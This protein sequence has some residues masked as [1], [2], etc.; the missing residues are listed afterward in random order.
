MFT[1]VNN[2]ALQQLAMVTSSDDL[3]RAVYSAGRG[4]NIYYV[5]IC[6]GQASGRLL[7]AWTWAYASIAKPFL[8]DGSSA[9]CSLTRAWSVRKTW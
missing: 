8:I 1:M 6:A 3:E 2:Q 4:G 9:A 5:I 7:Y